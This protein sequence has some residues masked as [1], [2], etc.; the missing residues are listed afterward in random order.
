MKNVFQ[1]TSMVLYWWLLLLTLLLLLSFRLHV[2]KILF[3]IFTKNT[4][5]Y[6]G[7]HDNVSPERHA[8]NKT[9]TERCPVMFITLNEA[10]VRWMFIVPIS[11]LFTQHEVWIDIQPIERL[12]GTVSSLGNKHNTIIKQRR[13]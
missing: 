7:I 8:W 2:W 12:R 10:Y 3:E 11:T 4:L 9:K 13:K 6:E 5:N 1:T